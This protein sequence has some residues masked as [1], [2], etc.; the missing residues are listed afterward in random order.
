MTKLIVF[1][2]PVL[3]SESQDPGALVAVEALRSDGWTIA[4][5]S[6][7]GHCDVSKA[8]EDIQATAD[9]FGIELAAFCPV[10]DGSEMI[11]LA[12][13]NGQ[14]RDSRVTPSG[15][16][17]LFGAAIP[18]INFWLPNTGMLL[19]S[20]ERSNLEGGDRCLFV[21]E[22]FIDFPNTNADDFQFVF[23]HE[24]RSESTLST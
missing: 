6:N 24:W 1:D 2:Y 9:L 4:I 14:W 17:A 23:A 3:V 15:F 7:Q 10:E 21:S 13:I 12:K 8:H 16:E 19:F 18:D 22:H 11:S 5:V 20:Q